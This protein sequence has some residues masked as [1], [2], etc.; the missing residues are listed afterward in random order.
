VN[1]DLGVRVDGRGEGQRL[2][3]L[4]LEVVEALDA[5]AELLVQRA[6][7]N[8]RRLGQR[9]QPVGEPA[10]NVEGHAVV[11]DLPD[12]GLLDRDR[13]L[14]QLLEE[15]LRQRGGLDEEA[16]DQPPSSGPGGISAEHGSRRL[17]RPGRA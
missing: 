15:H 11:R 2:L 16:A 13:V 8:R 6:P 5:A 9:V 7:A 12:R 17:C 14:L 10:V 3:E 4:V 1:F